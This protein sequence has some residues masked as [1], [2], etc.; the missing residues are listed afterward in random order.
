MEDNFSNT[1]VWSLD[2]ICPCCGLQ[3]IYMG[4]TLCGIDEA[5]HLF[6]PCG[7]D[8]QGTEL[9]LVGISDIDKGK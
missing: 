1:P 3:S 9:K 8:G 5:N 7:W 6:C 4:S 2:H